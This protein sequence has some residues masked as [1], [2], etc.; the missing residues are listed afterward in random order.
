MIRGIGHPE[1]SFPLQVYVE[2]SISAA[3]G[4]GDWR[5]RRAL[6]HKSSKA[7]PI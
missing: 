2:V 5:R 6:L 4:S 1:L 3:N 7:V